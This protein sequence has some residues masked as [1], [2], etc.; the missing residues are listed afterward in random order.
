MPLAGSCRV[1]TIGSVLGGS[2][3]Q[4]IPP[5][6]SHLAFSPLRASLRAG[7]VCLLA[8]L[9]LPLVAAGIVCAE[10]GLLETPFLAPP[11]DEVAQSFDSSLHPALLEDLIL[12]NLLLDGEAVAGD[13]DLPAVGAVPLSII[14][15]APARAWIGDD[16]MWDLEDTGAVVPRPATARSADE[17]GAMG[18]LHASWQIVGKPRVLL[19]VAA[20]AAAAAILLFVTLSRAV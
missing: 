19:L 15:I 17:A 2:P 4:G 20:V 1:A 8:G 3:R 6:M 18:L 5:L 9:A 11:L 10:P 12:E 7:S 14:S 16:W 13:S